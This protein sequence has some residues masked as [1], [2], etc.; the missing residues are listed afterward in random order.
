MGQAL[1]RHIV[2]TSSR[3]TRASENQPKTEEKP[4]KRQFED[5]KPKAM[6]KKLRTEENESP[7]SSKVILQ[8]AYIEHSYYSIS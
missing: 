3:G 4:L 8:H 1:S 7:K 2:G 5:S 6:P